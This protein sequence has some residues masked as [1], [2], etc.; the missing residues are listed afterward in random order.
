MWEDIQGKL[1]EELTSFVNEHPDSLYTP[2]V[3]DALETYEENN[4]QPYS[5][6]SFNEL[7]IL[8]ELMD[9]NIEFDERREVNRWPLSTNTLKNYKQYE[10]TK[11]RTLL[12]NDSSFEFLSLY[13]YASVNDKAL[14]EQLKS[15]AAQ[16]DIIDWMEIYR[17][18]WKTVVVWKR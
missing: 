14:S 13:M 8:F 16:S 4:W 3:T 10:E 9:E 15:D 18:Y 6:T 1:K 7:Y 12:S 2:I 5:Y 17:G 11:D